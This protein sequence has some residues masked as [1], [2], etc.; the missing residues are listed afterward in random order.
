MFE[1]RVVLGN[2]FCMEVVFRS[3]EDYR[4]SCR[5]G[6]N[7]LVDYK[8]D[9]K[10]HRMVACGRASVYEFKSVEKLRYEFERDAQDA[11]RQG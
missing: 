2:G 5:K 10:R 7:L 9:G 4:L 3:A 8:R 6:N 11:Q 1:E